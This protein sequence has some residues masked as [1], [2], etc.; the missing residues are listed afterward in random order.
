MQQFCV[1]KHRYGPRS[2]KCLFLS[3]DNSKLHVF[4]VREG[5]IVLISEFKLSPKYCSASLYTLI[6]INKTKYRQESGGITLSIDKWGE[7]AQA[8]S[9]L[10]RIIKTIHPNISS[11]SWEFLRAFSEKWLAETETYIR[12]QTQGLKSK[13]NGPTVSFLC[14]WSRTKKQTAWLEQSN[15]LFQRRNMARG[16]HWGITQYTRKQGNGLCK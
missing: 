3:E 14:M 9:L 12:W 5:L 7:P 6:S 16:V 4:V 8:Q 2:E 13:N 1:G 11:L 15:Q 10:H